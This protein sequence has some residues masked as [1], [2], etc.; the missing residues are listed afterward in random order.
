MC[1][2]SHNPCYFP[3]CVCNHLM[4]NRACY[5]NE[6][7]AETRMQLV[8]IYWCFVLYWE[9]V[10]YM[11]LLMFM[12]VC[13]L[14]R[15]DRWRKLDGYSL[16]P[17]Q[18]LSRNIILCIVY[19]CVCVLCCSLW[20]DDD[21]E[22]VYFCVCVLCDSL[23][24]EEDE[25]LVYCVFMCLCIMWQLMT[26]GGWRACV[27]C[28]YVFV[29]CDS[30]WQEEDEEL[31]YCVFMCLCI[32]WQLMTGGGWRACVLCIY[33]LVY[34]VTAYD[35]RRMKSLCIVYLCVCVLCDSLWQEEDEELVYYVFMCL[36]IM[37]Q[38][39]TGGG[40]RAC[41]L[42]I[43]VFVYYVAAYDRRRTKSLPLDQDVFSTTNLGE[44]RKKPKNSA[45]YIV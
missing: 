27:L 39:M 34:Y 11:Y 17:R 29:L 5:S 35:R 6:L 45:Y 43:Y 33:V 2:C 15:K 8:L 4:C 31:V 14:C 26:G 9:W 16:P 42:C 24:Q 44:H 22:I 32:M 36:C 41:L 37:W 20:Q 18:S 21:E 23:W 25:E 10:L 30:L 28:I 40:W 1:Y 19:L 38:L 13:S 12:D 7:V 3:R